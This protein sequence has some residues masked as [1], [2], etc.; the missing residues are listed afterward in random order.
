MKMRKRKDRGV[1]GIFDR[2]M[3]KRPCPEVISRSSF[4]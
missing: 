2:G 1:R 4:F 3:G